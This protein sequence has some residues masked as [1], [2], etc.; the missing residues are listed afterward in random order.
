M[1]GFIG[2]AICGAALANSKT[3]RVQQCSS[4][5]ADIADSIY[6]HAASAAKATD[7]RIAA[8]FKLA[9][10]RELF[11]ARVQRYVLEHNVTLFEARKVIELSEHVAELNYRALRQRLTWLDTLREEI[12]MYTQLSYLYTGSR[13]SEAHVRFTSLFDAKRRGGAKYITPPNMRPHTFHKYLTI[14]WPVGEYELARFGMSKCGFKPD[15]VAND[16]A[17]AGLPLYNQY[18]EK[19]KDADSVVTSGILQ[20]VTR[21]TEDQNLLMF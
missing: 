13:M 5:A 16:W 21:V 7:K 9:A 17:E 11:D 10:D 14:P 12:K 4:G 15:N 2:G 19:V 1:L 3:I 8:D 20:M 18:A 6:S